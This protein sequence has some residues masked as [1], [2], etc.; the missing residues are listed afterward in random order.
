MIRIWDVETG[1]EIT[2][3]PDAGHNVSE[4]AFSPDGEFLAVNNSYR[5]VSI[6][7]FSRLVEGSLDMSELVEATIPTQLDVLKPLGINFSLDGN[8]LITSLGGNRA[9]I[10]DVDS[11]EK[12]HMLSGHESD[13]NSVAFHPN[14]D[15][16]ATA[17]ADGTARIWD[18]ETGESIHTLGGHTGSVKRVVFSPDG[19]RLA[20]ASMDG[21]AKLWDANTGE[22]LL[23]L[24][25]HKGGI[26]D[27]AF[28]PDG[29]Q[30]YTAGMDGTV[31]VHL[32]DIDDLIALAHERRTR[33]FIQ[34]ECQQYLHLVSC[35]PEP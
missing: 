7:D 14:G 33:W 6:L 8:K 4:L 31:R 21:S 10:W 5:D 18:V 9:G 20:T 11:G 13:V 15:Q 28:S 26:T 3:I 27:V 22:E 2:S 1:E 24:Y 12:L 23:T 29:C 35:P 16:V 30:L 19:S 17:S 32:L 34:D 25:G